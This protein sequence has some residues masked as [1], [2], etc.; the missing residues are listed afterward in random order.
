MNSEEK[1]LY[2]AEKKLLAKAVRDMTQTEGWR[3]LKGHIEAQIENNSR[4]SGI[5]TTDPHQT[6][7]E[8]VTKQ[9]R[10][11]V[12]RGLLLEVERVMKEG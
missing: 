8:V 5:S 3:W 7:I 4:L 12:Y 6:F 2:D 1:K 10:H 9:K 11:D